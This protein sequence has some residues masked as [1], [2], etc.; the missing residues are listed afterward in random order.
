MPLAIAPTCKAGISASAPDAL[1][2]VAA[3]EPRVE[4]R[5]LTFDETTDRL[6][7]GC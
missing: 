6:S 3:V 2:R 1:E 4:R 7:I 5:R